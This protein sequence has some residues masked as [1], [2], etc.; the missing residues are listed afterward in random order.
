M[1][2]IA[3][4]LMT[5]PLHAHS[6]DPVVSEDWAAEA[7]APMTRKTIRDAIRATIAEEGPPPPSDRTWIYSSDRRAT[8]EQAFEAA[9]VPG[10]LSPDGLKHQATNIGPI[11]IGGLLA[12]PLVIVAKV[13]GKCK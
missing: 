6:A 12:A 1:R 7:P 9:R 11:K 3:I 13:R 4:M 2:I 10:C 5:L 8:L